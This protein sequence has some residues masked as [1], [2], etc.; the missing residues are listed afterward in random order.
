MIRYVR[1]LLVDF[2][3]D[4]LF[5]QTDMELTFSLHRSGHPFWTAGTVIHVTHCCTKYVYCTTT[6]LFLQNLN[7]CQ[8]I[9][10]CHQNADAGYDIHVIAIPGNCRREDFQGSH[11][12]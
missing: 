11:A 2:D 1:L 8:L 3:G 7:A 10:R 12:L 9:Q 5:F 4:K 6:Q